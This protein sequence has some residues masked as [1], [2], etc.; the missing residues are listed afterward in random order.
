MVILHSYVAVYQR[1]I[2]SFSMPFDAESHFCSPARQQWSHWQ[3]ESGR[4]AP[5]VKRKLASEIREEKTRQALGLEAVS[6][7]WLFQWDCTFYTW[8]FVCSY[9]WYPAW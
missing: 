7:N 6:Y 3:H 1:V 9:K 5:P 2:P 8:D 4:V